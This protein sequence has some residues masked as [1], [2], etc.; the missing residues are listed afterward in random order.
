MTGTL[1]WATIVIGFIVLGAFL[2]YW[3]VSS[4]IMENEIDNLNNYIDTMKK[5]RRIEMKHQSSR[6]S[7]AEKWSD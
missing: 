1:A 7:S 6:E 4:T 5:I 3:V 2:V